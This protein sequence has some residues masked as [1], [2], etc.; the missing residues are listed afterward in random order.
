MFVT[1]NVY[2]RISDNGKGFGCSA[3]GRAGG[4]GV[5]DGHFRESSRK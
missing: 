3:G 4:G 1:L 2:S 5:E